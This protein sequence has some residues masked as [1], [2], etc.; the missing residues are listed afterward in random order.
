MTSIVIRIVDLKESL[1]LMIKATPTIYPPQ[2][3]VDKIALT[4][5]LAAFH[6]LRVHIQRIQTA[7]RG[8]EQPVA[9]RSSKT[10]I[11]AAFWQ[12]N[13][14]NGFALRAKY[15]YTVQFFR[16]HAPS[17]PQIPTDIDSQT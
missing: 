5:S 17:A 13:V 15:P 9:M 14:S 8:H 12:N 3:D 11:C 16:T 6:S 4:T 10:Q 1:R 7:A 2:L